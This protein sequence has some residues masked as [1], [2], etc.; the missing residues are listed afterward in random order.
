MCRNQDTRMLFTSFGAASALTQ[1]LVHF[2]RGVVEIVFDHSV[3]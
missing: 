2:V 3:V 1:R